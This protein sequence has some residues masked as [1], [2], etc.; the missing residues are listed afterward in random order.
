[1][2]R[3]GY[4]SVIG[5][6]RSDE[7]KLCTKARYDQPEGAH[8]DASAGGNKRSKRMSDHW[9]PV[10]SRP[11]CRG[12]CSSVCPWRVRRDRFD[13]VHPHQAKPVALLRDRNERVDNLMTRTSL[14]TPGRNS[15]FFK[16]VIC[17][18]KLSQRR[19]DASADRLGPYARTVH[20]PKRSA[21]D[22]L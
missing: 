2:D 20:E 21:S 17:P 11:T 9:F 12:E 19:Q 14:M 13:L 6:Q 8:S 22:T 7:Y 4:G 18:N 10:R 1:M 3:D 16:A 15:F 5:L